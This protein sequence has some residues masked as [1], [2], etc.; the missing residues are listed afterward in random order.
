MSTTRGRPP[1]L[2]EREQEKKKDLFVL[3]VTLSNKKQ[4]NIK[5]QKNCNPN[6]LA[7]LFCYENGLSEEVKIELREL[8]YESLK[9]FEA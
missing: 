2:L 8:L 1:S 4:Y 7:D 9:Q 3:S 6:K 5:V